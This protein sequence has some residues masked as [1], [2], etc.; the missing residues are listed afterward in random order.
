MSACDE[1]YLH[2]H[3]VRDAWHGLRTPS[4]AI[5]RPL[6]ERQGRAAPEAFN[7]AFNTALLTARGKL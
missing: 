1:N 4:A 5:D 2:H 3:Q 6:T 7:I